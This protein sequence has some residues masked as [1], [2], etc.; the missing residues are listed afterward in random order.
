MR[1]M[2][3]TPAPRLLPLGETCDSVRHAARLRILI[4]AADYF[5]ALRVIRAR[6]SVIIV[7][8]DIDSRSQHNGIRSP[9]N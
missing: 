1:P 3:R 4:D 5:A 6:R 7:G 2:T 9:V 8:W